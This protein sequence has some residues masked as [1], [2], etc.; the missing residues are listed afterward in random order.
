MLGTTLHHRFRLEQVLH[1]APT[2]PLYLATDERSGEMLA[3]KL[4]PP[5]AD[6]AGEDG[7]RYRR[8]MQR[9][10][11][12]THP[13]LLVPRHTGQAEGVAF[14]VLPYYP[15]DDL[16]AVLADGPLP[17]AQGAALLRQAAEALAALH[18]AGL[19]HDNLKPSNVLLS[20]VDDE[21]QAVLCD[22]LRSLLFDAAPDAE[23]AAYLAPEQVPWLEGCVDA[24]SDLYALGAVA[25]RALTGAPPY[26]AATAQEVL[27]QHVV[28][29]VPDAHQRNPNIPLRLAAILARLLAKHP[30][31]RYQSAAGLLADLERWDAP[32]ADVLGQTERRDPLDP[33]QRP[34]GRDAAREALLT[35]LARAGGGEGALVWLSGEAGSGRRTLL[36]DLQAHLEAAQALVLRAS[37]PPREWCAPFQLPVDLLGALL[38]RWEVLPDLR[39]R[40]TLHRLHSALGENAAVLTGLVPALRM[41]LPQDQDA[42][43]LPLGRERLRTLHVLCEALLALADPRYPLVLWLEE[44]QAAD[45]D[46]QEWLALLARRLGTAPVLVVATTTPEAGAARMPGSS[47]EAAGSRPGL[48]H[49]E[50]HPLGEEPVAAWL[51][52]AL[53]VADPTAIGADLPA[54]LARWLLERSGGRPLALRLA[55]R[56]LMAKGLLRPEGSGPGWMCD[57]EALARA[58]WP[59]SLAALVQ[60]RLELLSDEVLPV[61]Q[62]VAAAPAG[63]SFARLSALLEHLPPLV[64]LEQ[65]EA[66]IAE[67]VLVR[68]GAL[69]RFT[70]GLLREAVWRGCPPHL[71]ESYHQVLGASLEAQSALPPLERHHRTALHFRYGGEDARYLEHGCRLVAEAARQQALRGLVQWADQL[72]PLLRGDAR[73]A[74]LLIASGTAQAQL[75]HPEQALSLLEAARALGLG[76][77][78]ELDAIA[79]SAWAERVRGRTEA[80][81]AWVE[82]GLAR[83]GESLPANP[84]G[85]ALA[86]L[87]GAAI[88]RYEGLRNAA[89][90]EPPQLL[91]PWER[92]I[93]ELLALASSLLASTHPFRAALADERILRLAGGRA[94]SP[95]LVAALVRLGEAEGDPDGEPFTQ[96]RA[97]LERHGFAHA[98]AAFHAA[99]GRCRLACGRWR[100]AGESLQA[101]QEGFRQVGALP[102]E[103]ETLLARVELARLQGP[104]PRL[105]QAVGTL[106]ALVP[107]LADP[108]QEAAAVGWSAYATALAGELAPA[109]AAE[110]LRQAGQR[111]GAA[112]RGAAARH[113]LAL[114]AELALAADDLGE[115]LGVV[116]GEAAL[117]EAPE[118]YGSLLLQA[119]QAEG[120]LVQA[121]LLPDEAEH[122]LQQARALLRALHDAPGQSAMLRADLARVEVLERFL[123]SDDTAAM[124]LAEVAVAALDGEGA[125]LAA[126]VLRLRVAEGLKSGGHSDWLHWGGEALTAFDVL[127][128]PLYLQ[129]TRRLLELEA[130]PADAVPGGAATP[131]APAGAVGLLPLLERLA[132]QGAQAPAVLEEAMLAAFVRAAEA[133]YA[134]WFAPDS[135]GQLAYRRGYPEPLLAPEQLNQW[136]ADSVWKQGRPDMLEHYRPARS[137]A[138]PDQPLPEAQSLLGVPL[139]AGAGRLGVVLLGS[140]ASRL[141]FDRAHA[142]ALAPLGRE[143]GALLELNA[144]L[145]AADGE[146]GQHVAEGE[147]RAHLLHWAADAAEA[148]RLDALLAAYCTEIAEPQGCSGALL[149]LR[150]ADAL[151]LAATHG[152]VPDVVALA[153]LFPLALEQGQ[154][155]AA[156][157]RQAP[158][159]GTAL[160]AP[161]ASPAEQA[162]L[163]ALGGGTALWLPLLRQGEAFG[164][165]LLVGDR[166]GLQGAGTLGRTFGEPLRLLAPA[167]HGAWRAEAARAELAATTE[168]AEALQRE[169]RLYRR[170]AP[171]GLPVRAEDLEPALREGLERTLPVLVGEVPGLGQ[172]PARGGDGPMPALRHYFERVQHGLALHEGILA[173]VSLPQWVATYPA[174]VDGALWG[175]QTLYQLLLELRDEATALGI[176]LPPTGLGLHVGKVLWGALPA[177]E[178]LTPVLAGEA[179]RCAG[180]LA[181]MS[182]SLRCGILVSQHTVQALGDPSRFDLRPLGKLRPVP[183]EPRLDVFELYSVREPEVVAP[184]RSLQPVWDEAPREF[185]LGR[186]R[187]AAGG[188]HRYAQ[189]LPLDRPARFFLRQCRQRAQG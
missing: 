138:A 52:D 158:L 145:L 16:D 170:L 21:L 172:Q 131:L 177:G 13:H 80:A 43:P 147:G 175:A 10:A 18:G 183:G 162:L 15:S 64:L 128:V 24:R 120:H 5:A 135:D 97:I 178:A 173:R 136:L 187:S 98:Q 117:P 89:L 119:V 19:L 101:A 186:W 118:A 62:A 44:V 113:L 66:A 53:G 84:V 60:H 115:F 137:G 68:E 174:S 22:P 61:L 107:V 140:A 69:L 35:A 121:G 102:D 110:T 1:R 164:M 168:R 151:H 181:A 34:F 32:G 46:S 179:I 86:R 91:T 9:L 79:Y 133:E 50:L 134:A 31:D 122:H 109:A 77:E 148:E 96:A 100:A 146:T 129:A 111:L 90:G 105:R 67:G 6:F 78:A 87:S 180:R 55:L 139:G 189:R 17:P 11:G 95:Q 63:C 182:I 58:S 152:A 156:L 23:A 45:P 157:A 14:Q 83:A 171:P 7:L 124:R 155:E 154:A 38:A 166:V 42:T 150:G 74:D 116:R 2:G 71:Q 188:F 127:Q 76:A 20:R 48:Q 94:P 93:A 57:W 88:R 75:G 49:V 36:R 167:I 30:R 161:P 37:A 51:A 3:V 165:L 144:R 81:L 163:S 108:A 106:Q 65:V 33:A 92:R 160:D 39:R 176:G 56:L 73:L 72:Q 59:E 25:F 26:A 130:P 114:A 27:R 40:D 153:G 125:Q 54:R 103:A 29:R 41:L 104:L 185:Q 169:A 126:A 142:A 149:L 12:L 8:A 99:L 132:G 184:M 141:V 4:F 85:T 112:E 159:A 82:Q 70:H 47:P 143:A 28:A 123:V